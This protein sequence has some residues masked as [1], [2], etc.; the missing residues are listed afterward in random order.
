MRLTLHRLPWGTLAERQHSLNVTKP[1]LNLVCMSQ[2]LVFPVPVL[3]HSTSCMA[4][5]QPDETSGGS[6]QRNL[7]ISAS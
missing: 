3:E 5:E 2:H 1:F 6:A 7:V 4:E